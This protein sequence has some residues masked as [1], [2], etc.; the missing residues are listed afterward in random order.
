MMHEDPTRALAEFAQGLACL[1]PQTLQQAR[2]AFSNYVGCTL[3]ASKD[4]ASVHAL[5]HADEFSGRRTATVQGQQVRLDPLHAALVNCLQ[6]SIQT[7]DDT[8]LASVI[9]P[10]GPVAAALVALL[11]HDPRL[12]VDGQGFLTALGIGIEVSCRVALALTSPPAQPHLGLFMTGITGG[13]GAAAAC[14][15]VLGLDVQRTLWAMGTAASQAGGLR[16]THTTMA[17]GLVPALGARAGLESALLARQ[18][19]DGPERVLEHPNGV[20]ATLAPGSNSALALQGLG[21]SFEL[22]EL[23]YKPYPCGVVIHPIIDGCLALLPQLSGQ[24]PG[25]SIERVS[26]E[27]HPLVL[28]L[29]GTRHPAH[30]LACNASVYHW[31]AAALTR[32]RAGIAEASEAA[33]HQHDIAALR[34]RIKALPRDDLARD[35]A[36][37]QVHLTSGRV[38]DMHIPHARGSR[39]RPLTDPELQAKLLAMATPVLGDQQAQRLASLCNALADAGPGWQGPLFAATVPV[40]SR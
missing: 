12:Q 39:D 21:V 40:H 3:G 22:D 18:G 16:A 10:T 34:D 32:G 35:E 20:L 38:L 2:R 36:R 25:E 17:A 23:S 7:F 28:K 29:T 31:A 5:A 8:H 26:L 33:L 24:S 19:F 13:I 9:H 11:E 1:P 37:V 15:R 30:A 4:M 14:A 27:V 6:S